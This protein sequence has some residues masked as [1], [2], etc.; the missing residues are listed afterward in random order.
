MAFTVQ[1]MY[2]PPPPPPLDRPYLLFANLGVVQRRDLDNLQASTL[3]Y[4]ADENV[5]DY[6]GMDLDM[7]SVGCE[8]CEFG[9]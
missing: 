8:M 6:L 2:P 3:V 4:Q 1:P 7:R 5:M 9:F